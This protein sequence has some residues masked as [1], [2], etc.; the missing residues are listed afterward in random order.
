[1]AS[2]IERIFGGGIPPERRDAILAYLTQEW[3]LQGIQDA[4]GGLYNDVLT[5][6]GGGATAGSEGMSEIVSAAKRQ[7][8]AY[9]SL[10]RQHT[11][12]GPVPDEAGACYLRWEH[13]YLTLAEWA[14]AMAA[15]YEGFNSGATP[16]EGRLQE[17]QRAEQK[18]ERDAHK[19]DV[20]LLKRIGAKV[21]DVRWLMKESGDAVSGEPPAGNEGA[22]IPHKHFH[23]HP[24]PGHSHPVEYRFPTVDNIHEHSH[25]HTEAQMAEKEEEMLKLAQRP[26][27]GRQEKEEAKNARNS[28]YADTDERLSE[29]LLTVKDMPTGW[30]VSPPYEEDD[31]RADPYHIVFG[32]LNQDASACARAD[33]Q[34]SEVEHVADL[35]HVIY[36]FPDGKAK[37]AIEEQCAGIMDFDDPSSYTEWAETAKKNLDMIFFTSPLSF[38]KIGDETFGCRM[39]G[40]SRLGAVESDVIVWR[41]GDIAEVIIYFRRANFEGLDSEETMYLAD[42][43][44]KAI[45]E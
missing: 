32:G 43:K 13:T 39:S 1:M 37:R 16:H 27:L 10:S 2:F 17:L 35:V 7:A 25:D 5:K 6:Y 19:E 24:H 4:E 42:E 9:A 14:S 33:F 12:L 40:A 28:F 21:E 18:A 23:Q 31:Q 34:E 29:A 20:K 3:K 8:E 44:L 41:R 22:R 36:L 38:P 15:A 30:T 11:A 45:L 26:G